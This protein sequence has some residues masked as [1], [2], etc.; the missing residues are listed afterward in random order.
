MIIY[1][2]F[3]KSKNT[4]SECLEWLQNKKYNIIDLDLIDDIYRFQILPNN[5]SNLIKISID[6]EKQIEAIV[7]LDYI[8]NL[9][10]RNLVYSI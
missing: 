9:N 1:I 6:R 10:S 3:S 8:K 7:T 2:L 5:K 4:F